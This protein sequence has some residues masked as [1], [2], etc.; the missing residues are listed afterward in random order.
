MKLKLEQIESLESKILKL[1]NEMSGLHTIHAEQKSE[2]YRMKQ[3]AEAL[4][5]QKLSKTQQKV[6][7]YKPDLKLK[8]KEYQVCN[9]LYAFFLSG[10]KVMYLTS[11][12]FIINK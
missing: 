7:D 3:L 11:N 8:E 1:E 4:L 12:L 5:Q 6:K 10:R 2:L 9:L